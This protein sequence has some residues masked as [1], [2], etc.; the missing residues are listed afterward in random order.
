MRADERALNSENSEAMRAPSDSVAWD[1]TAPTVS[2]GEETR[3]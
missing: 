3:G 1:Q 2:S